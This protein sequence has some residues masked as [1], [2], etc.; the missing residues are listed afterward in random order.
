[1]NK[2]NDYICMYVKTIESLTFEVNIQ[3]LQKKIL[4]NQLNCMF[5]KD[6]Y[7]TME[8]RKI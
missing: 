2:L 4:K 1:M 7:I 5:L 3:N 8:M 6:T